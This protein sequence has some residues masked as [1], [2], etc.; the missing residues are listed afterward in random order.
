M[1]VMRTYISL[2]SGELEDSLMPFVVY[3]SSDVVFLHVCIYVVPFFLA[4]QKV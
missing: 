2:A 1:T 3:L 4:L